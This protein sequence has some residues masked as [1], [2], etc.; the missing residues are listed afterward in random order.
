MNCFNKPTHL[1]VTMRKYLCFRPFSWTKDGIMGT[2]EVFPYI[3]MLTYTSDTVQPTLLIAPTI[4]I[5]H[6]AIVRP[7][8]NTF[9]GNY[10]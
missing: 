8:N 9:M 7:L 1:Y 5:L 4:L 6:I 2:L 3:H 10:W